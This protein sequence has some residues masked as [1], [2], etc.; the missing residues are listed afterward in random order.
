MYYFPSPILLCNWFYIFVLICFRIL[1]KCSHYVCSLS[2]ISD[3]GVGA[4]IDSYY[5]Y[6]LKGYIMLGKDTY[7]ERFNKVFFY[8]EMFTCI[9]WATWIL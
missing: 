1:I 5:E 9:F 6:L 4:G 8:R 7:L 3:S 2:V